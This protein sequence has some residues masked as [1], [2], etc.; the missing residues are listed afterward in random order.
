MSNNDADAAAPRSPSAPGR[1]AGGLN[2][3]LLGLSH[4]TRAPKWSFNGRSQGART[5]DGPGPG[6]YI[7]GAPDM[8]SRFKKSPNHAFGVSGRETLDKHKVPGPGAYTDRR[9]IGAGGAAYSLTPR[10]PGMVPRDAKDFP[11]PGAHDLKTRIGEGPRSSISPRRPLVTR[12]GVP[13]PGEYDQLDQ[14]TAEKTPSWGFGT[15]QR[16]D[17]A[18]S[19]HA[20]TP[21][22]G[23]YIMATVVGEG[24][25]YSMQARKTEPRPQLSPGPGAHGGHYTTFA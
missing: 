4:I 20:A 25:K 17:T 19:V 6:A 2:H 10:R 14:F 18:G 1:V 23:A 7:M 3:S 11:G 22:P 9:G 24:P 21:G 5:T 13:G 12:G 15:S 16:P 8:T